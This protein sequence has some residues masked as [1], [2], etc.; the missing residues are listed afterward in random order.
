MNTEFAQRKFLLEQRLKTLTAYPEGRFE[1]FGIVICAGGPLF[2]T[3]AYVLVH[4]LRHSL[5]CTLPIEIWHLGAKEMSARMALMLRE[6]NTRTVDANKELTARGLSIAD[7]WQLKCFALMWCDFQH[8]LL[9]DADQVPTRDPGELLDWPEYEKTGAIFWPD[10]DNI[11]D[12][13]P[14]WDVCGL[15][16]RTMPALESG[17]L[18]I[19]KSRHWQALEIALHLNEHADFYYRLIYGDKDTYLLG[20]LLAGSS[21]KL[22]PYRPISDRGLCLYQR[23]FGGEILFQHRT[24]AKWRYAGKQDNLPGFWGEEACMD[25]LKSLRRGWNGLIVHSP[26]KS[27]NAR[28]AER[29]LCEGGI[30]VFLVAGEP[31]VR[32]EMLPEGEIGEGRAPDRMNWYCEEFAEGIYLVITDA[33]APSWRLAQVSQEQWCG[34]SIGDT[35]VRVYAVQSCDS[36]RLNAIMRRK[37]WGHWPMQDRYSCRDDWGN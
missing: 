4:L 3:N 14:I 37:V 5:G 36:D 22:I 21:F 12:E 9:L 23:D 31:P 11:V 1:G 6:L 20:M 35:D 19:D 18:L 2:F 32:L 26:E 25:A 8:A 30:L 15:E 16:A 17:Q 28:E 27:P 29:K 33:F 24:G 10:L 34:H 7:G 13:N